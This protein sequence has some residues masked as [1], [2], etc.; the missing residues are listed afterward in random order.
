MVKS[1][2]TLAISFAA[3]FAAAATEPHE[4]GGLEHIVIFDNSQPIP[5]EVNEVLT[6]L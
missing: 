2:L 6:R 5:P 3:T 1:I 4:S